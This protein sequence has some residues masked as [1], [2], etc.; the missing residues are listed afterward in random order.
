MNRL[1]SGAAALAILAV[2][3]PASAEL[4]ATLQPKTLDAFKAYVQ[5]VES[6]LV[7]R[8]QGPGP[9]LSLEDSR[10]DTER[11]LGGSFLIR[12]T[13]AGPVGIPV[14]SFTTGSAMFSSRTLHPRR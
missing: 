3:H 13:G 1:N 11:V 6:R 10:T 14:V 8:E 5:N 2:A 9:L 4:K 12:P 7:E